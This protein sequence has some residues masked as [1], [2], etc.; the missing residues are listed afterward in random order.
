MPISPINR[1]KTIAVPLDATSGNQ[2]I[3]VHDNAGLSIGDEL[4]P[5]YTVVSYNCFVKNLKAFTQIDS[6]PEINLPDFDIAD[7]ETDKLYKTLTVEWQS[8]RKQLNL[9]VSTGFNWE[10]VGSTSILNPSGYPFRIYSLLDMFTDN[11]YFELGENG[12]IGVQMQDVGYG[13]LSGNDSVVI[14]GSYV[15][16]IFLQSQEAPITVNVTIPT[17]PITPTT[18][19]IP[20]TPTTPTGVDEDMANWIVTTGNHYAATGD[21]ILVDA[22]LG[23]ADPI[24]VPYGPMPGNTIKV[25][26]V[27]ANRAAVFFSGIPPFKGNSVDSINIPNPNVEYTLV[28]FGGNEGWVGDLPTTP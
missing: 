8:A 19:T 24:F 27:G 2:V 13:L 4:F 26:K 3:T 15:E 25:M 28:Y 16:E 18:P 12:K 9:F 22:T 5:G 14:H 11:L 20:A 6:L 1:A 23:N 17:T 10:Q 7:S 21:K